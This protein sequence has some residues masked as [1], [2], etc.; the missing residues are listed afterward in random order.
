MSVLDVIFIG[1]MSS[2]FKKTIFKIQGK[3]LVLNITS[4]ILCYI[5]MV[6]G[7]NYFIIS[8]KKSVLDAFLLGVLVYGVFETTNK[9]LLKGWSWD[10]VLIDTLWG[11]ILF[12][13]TTY[14][15][16]ILI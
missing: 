15:V 6:F 5:L 8:S 4:A 10:L 12:S 7:L 16:N 14:I 13:V 3:S 11:G 1:L 9:A 2:K